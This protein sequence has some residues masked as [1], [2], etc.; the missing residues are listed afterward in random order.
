[1]REFRREDGEVTELTHV[2]KNREAMREL[3]VRHPLVSFV[4]LFY[5]I[6]WTAWLFLY[7][8]D[9]G[10]VNGFGIIAGAGPALAAMLVSALQKPESSGIPTGKRWRLFALIAFLAMAVMALRRIW[11]G[12][13]LVNVSGRAVTAVTYQT[14]TAFLVDILVA[15]VVAFF[16][17]GVHSPRQGVRDLLHS[18]DPF[19]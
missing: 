13:Q 16:L 2:S 1:V 18:L 5:A 8:L 14:I 19:S 6:S 4:I 9:L 11:T 17:S 7:L 15:A 3:V 12:E 10:A